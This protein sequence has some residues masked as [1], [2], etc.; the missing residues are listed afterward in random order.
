MLITAGLIAS[1][2]AANEPLG[3]GIC[4]GRIGA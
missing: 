2:T 4:A 3:S 1:E